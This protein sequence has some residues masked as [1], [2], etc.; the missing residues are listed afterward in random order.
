LN[1][2]SG[3]VFGIRPQKSAALE[4]TVLRHELNLMLSRTA[5]LELNIKQLNERDVSLRAIIARRTVAYDSASRIAG[6]GTRLE[7]TR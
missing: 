5:Q 7:V 6:S 2:S 4:N 3:D 1:E